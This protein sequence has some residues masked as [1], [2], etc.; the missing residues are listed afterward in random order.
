[1]NNIRVRVP[2]ARLIFLCSS[3]RLGVF[4]SVGQAENNARKARYNRDP[5]ARRKV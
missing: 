1:M 2:Q 4:S 5:G 3:I